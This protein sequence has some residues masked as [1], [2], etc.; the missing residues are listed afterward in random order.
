MESI[1]LDELRQ[2]YNDYENNILDLAYRDYSIILPLKAYNYLRSN[3]S[4]FSN[5]L[6]E[7]VNSYLIYSNTSIVMHLQVLAG[8][9]DCIVILLPRRG[10]D[11]YPYKYTLWISLLRHYNSIITLSLLASPL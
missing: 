7:Y 4:I 5:S 8:K 2:V 3:P 9:F 11:T 1:F 6:Q 10:K